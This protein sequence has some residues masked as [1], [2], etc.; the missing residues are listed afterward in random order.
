MRKFIPLALS[1][2]AA[3]LGGCKAVVLAPAGDIA[4]QQRDLLILSTLLMLLII[5]PVMWLTIHFAWKYRASNTEAEYDPEWDH[6]TKLEL[7]IWACPLL[8]IICL[9]ALTWVGTHLLDPYRPL[10]RITP[11]QAVAQ[12]VK[13]LEVQVVALDW[14]WLFIY[15]EYGIAT[16]NEMAAPVN[17]PINFRITA[18]SVMNAFYV[19]ALAGMIY[20]MPGMETKLHAVIN[21]AGEY[22]GFSANYSGAGFSHMRFKFHGTDETGFQAWVDTVKA[23]ATNLDRN[24][25]LSKLERP[26]ENEPAA[27]FGKVDA[28]LY[29]AILNMCVNPGKMCMGMMMA[30]DAKGGLGKQG[31]RLVAPL[32]YDK[33]ERRGTSASGLEQTYITSICGPGEQQIGAATPMARKSRPQTPLLGFGLAMPGTGNG[34]DIAQ[35]LE[36]A[37]NQQQAQ[38]SSQMTPAKG[39]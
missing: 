34:H 38:Q 6:S 13:P 3:A 10:D 11:Q 22:D 25:Y 2:L 23:S 12:D 5:I 24:L 33:F 37:L 9:G 39:L 35:I 4:A 18:S 30:I 32:A 29:S 15:P 16:V 17:R 26:T 19:P 31:I 28:D 36:T 14:K 8:I 1:A 21:H 7:V 27:H 20:A